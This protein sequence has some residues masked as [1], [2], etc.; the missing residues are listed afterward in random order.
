MRRV[1]NA[2]RSRKLAFWLIGAFV[3]YS[4][5]ATSL[6]EGDFDAAYANPLFYAISTALAVAT[7]ACAWER[8]AGATRAWRA[9]ASV[10]ADFVERLRR[11]PQIEVPLAGGVEPDE[12]LSRVSRE[13]GRMRLLTRTGGGRLVGTSAR[14]AL[15]G[16]P[17]FHWA[18][19]ALFVVLAL[20]RLTRAEGLMGIP[21]GS[22]LPD[23]AESY[24]VLDQGALYG[25]TPS[26]LTIAVPELTLDYVAGG[27]DRGAAPTV[28]IREGDRVVASRIV[29]PNSPLRYGSLMIHSNAYG[30]AA[31]LS[32]EADG[33]SRDVDVLYDFTPEEPV[34]RN[35]SPLVFA[36]A[37]RSAVIDSYVPLD[38]QGGEAPWVLPA[39]PA[40]VW[41]LDES[42]DQTSGT[43]Q[44]G[45][46]IDL[47][48]GISLRLTGVTYYAR[49]SVV[50][51]W[52][53]YPLYAVLTLAVAGLALALL[54]PPKM[55]WVMLVES[56]GGTSLHARTRQSRA[57]RLFADSV[58]RILKDAAEGK[59]GPL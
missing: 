27:V 13:L 57:D 54:L 7:A 31:R 24:G 5:V 55:A 4:A 33:E 16:S 47:G 41:T 19:V 20:G 32:L 46:A 59:D 9:G 34:A 53:V 38:M 48:D 50:D 58:E 6:A 1:Y 2:L 30:L 40:V 36:V 23:A 22:S 29:Y 17:L 26:G 45:E 37:G 12:A 10:S 42:G 44:A 14:L 18:L 11:S 52:S 25:A 56:D 15:V 8:T 43:L 51:D 35:T 49:I 3:A 21:V 28:E 39:Q